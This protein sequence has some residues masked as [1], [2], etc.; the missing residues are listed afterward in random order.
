MGLHQK[1]T[2]RITSEPC[3]CGADDDHADPLVELLRRGLEQVTNGETVRR[4]DL[5]EDEWTDGTEA[6]E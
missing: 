5:L 6:S 3:N 4:D 2:D 1:I